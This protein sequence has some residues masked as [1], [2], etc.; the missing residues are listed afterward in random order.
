MNNLKFPRQGRLKSRKLIGQ[1]F[2]GRLS[3]GAFP[4]R[5]FWMEVPS[6]TLVEK[7]PEGQFIPIQV[8]FSV[9]KKK[10]KRAVDRNRLKRLIREAY[11]LQQTSLLDILNQKDLAIVG[12]WV[13]VGTEI[14]DFAEA[15]KAVAKTIQKLKKELI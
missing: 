13:Y 4:L 2:G 3:V 11:R 6:E 14:C 1:L 9:P 8:G 7:M 5:F 10:F 15:Q 12:M